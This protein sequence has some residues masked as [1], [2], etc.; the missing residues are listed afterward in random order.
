VVPAVAIWRACA[1]RALLRRRRS[2]AYTPGNHGVD[3][4]RSTRRSSRI[5]A[6]GETILVRGGV[7]EWD[8]EGEEYL[9]CVSGTFNRA[10]PQ[11]PRIGRTLQEQ[12]R[13]ADL[14]GS[15]C[16]AQPTNRVMELLAELIAYG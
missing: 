7:R 14:L 6:L 11:P 13:R 2:Q 5:Y 9:D 8:S 12:A 16:Q 4:C 1:C 15:V 3:G 10:R